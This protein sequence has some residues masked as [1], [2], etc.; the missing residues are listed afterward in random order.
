MGFEDRERHIWVAGVAQGVEE[1][2]CSVIVGARCTTQYGV[3][4]YSF[5]DRIRLVAAK[6]LPKFRPA[7][8]AVMTLKKLQVPGVN[9][10]L[11]QRKECQGTHPLRR[12][13]LGTTSRPPVEERTWSGA[14]Y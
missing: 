8:K 10:A 11:A 13:R 12:S 5:T 6:S 9:I 7:Q 1:L 4:A 14:K 3:R 2:A